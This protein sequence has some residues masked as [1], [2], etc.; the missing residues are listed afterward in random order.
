MAKLI[1]IVFS[2]L[3]LIAC[4]NSYCRQKKDRNNFVQHTKD[5]PKFISTDKTD[6]SQELDTKTIKVFK[7]DGSKQCQAEKAISVQK[8][9]EVLN[10][11]NIKV[12]KAEKAKD[13]LMRAQVCGSD[14]GNINIYEIPASQL[15][16]AIKMGFQ[17]WKE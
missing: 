14:T 10:K 2:T 17:E 16:E 12:S 15:E 3:S 8:M 1:F 5:L 7:A 13:G 6:L 9:Q 11:A 4:S